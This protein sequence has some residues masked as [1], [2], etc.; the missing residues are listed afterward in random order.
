VGR[1][2][3]PAGYAEG[4]DQVTA[5]RAR[6]T[7]KHGFTG[8]LD[9][10]MRDVYLHLAK[11]DFGPFRFFYSDTEDALYLQCIDRDGSQYR[12]VQKWGRPARR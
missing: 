4:V 3:R 10:A 6:P 5:G 9:A 12:T 2:H 1:D 8:P 11:C 7:K